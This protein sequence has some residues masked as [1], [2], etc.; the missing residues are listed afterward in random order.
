MF[1]Y[2]AASI[3]LASLK[4]ARNATPQA[5]KSDIIAKGSF[6]GLQGN[7]S[8]DSY[9]DATRDLFLYEIKNHS[10]VRIEE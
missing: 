5:I 4:S 2:E 9:G 3:L 8:F 1:G 6:S 10:F 7:I